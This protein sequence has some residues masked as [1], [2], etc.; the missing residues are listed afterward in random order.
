MPFDNANLDDTT[1]LLLDA[2]GYIERG[3]CRDALARDKEGA[4]VHPT[5]ERAVKWCINGSFIAAGLRG[6]ISDDHP[7]VS[8]LKRAIGGAN[9]VDFSNGNDKA[10]VLAAFD[11][12]ILRVE[13]TVARAVNKGEPT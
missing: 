9:L 7:A 10:V 12:A 3:L 13:A 2:R 8:R 11:R 4:E 6:R 1:R 5:D